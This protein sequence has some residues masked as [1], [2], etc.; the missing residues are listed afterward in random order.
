MTRLALLTTLLLSC[1]RTV[2]QREPDA[3]P[4]PYCVAALLVSGEVVRGCAESEARCSAAAEEVRR[5]G[6]LLGVKYVGECRRV[7]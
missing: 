4:T 3:R 2:P 1:A 5:N 6:V 7:P